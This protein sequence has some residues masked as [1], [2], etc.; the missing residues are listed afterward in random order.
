[1]SAA[2]PTE[3]TKRRAG[4]TFHQSPTLLTTGVDVDS[5][6]SD[7]AKDAK[8]SPIAFETHEVDPGKEGKPVQKTVAIGVLTFG[9]CLVAF[10]AAVDNTILGTAIPRITADFNSLQ[11]AGL[12]RSASLVASTALQLPY[13]KA[14]AQFNVKWIYIGSLVIFEAG[15]ILCAAAPNSGALVAGRVVSGAGAAALY[16]GAINM[17][18]IAAGPQ[19]APRFSA[20]MVGLASLVGPP[21]GGAFT[22]APRLTWRWCF[23]I[24][25]PIGAAAA[26]CILAMF[27]APRPSPPPESDTEMHGVG[28]AREAAQVDV[29]TDPASTAPPQPDGQNSRTASTAIS[30][31]EKPFVKK[32]RRMDPLGTALLIPALVSLLLALQWGGT[33]YP[34]SDGR[35]W[36]CLVCSGVLAALFVASLWVNGD[37]AVIPPRLLRD[38]SVLGGVLLVF[39]LSAALFTHVFFLPFYFQVVQGMSATASGLRILAYLG[40]MA[41]AGVFAGGAMSSRGALS[42]HRPYAWVGTALFVVGAGLLHMLSVDSG[43][44]IVVG[45]QLLSGVALGV[46]W[47][48]PYVAVQR[49]KKLAMRPGDAAI[50]NAMIAFSNSFGA[51]LGISIA[52]NVFATTLARGLADLPGLNSDQAHALAKAGQAAQLRDSDFVSP[53]LLAPVL[54]VFHDAITSTFTFAAVAGGVAFLCSFV[55]P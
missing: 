46:A 17:L 35:V 14:Y 8:S 27:R 51:A 29:E 18:A 32:V 34:W 9:L 22:D 31:M 7:S 26:V 49:S 30:L 1:M 19:R 36:G 47:Q 40:A 50:A 48:V 21:L 52:Q 33:E 11:D 54:Q 25:L 13:G 4:E 2:T 28:H 39:G 44:G 37:D 10:A 55:F 5:A 16:S 12:Y 53:E 38:R 20:S 41:L 43:L 23:W 24:N 42:H 3:E 6:K 15:S 45:F